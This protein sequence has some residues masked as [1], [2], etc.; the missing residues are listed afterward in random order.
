MGN[1]YAYEAYEDIK[2]LVKEINSSNE[3]NRRVILI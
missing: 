3:F 2:K 1:N